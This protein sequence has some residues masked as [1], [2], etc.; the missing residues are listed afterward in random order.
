MRLYAL[1]ALVMGG[2]VIAAVAAVPNLAD[3]MRRILIGAVA[4][5]VIVP[6]ALFLLAGPV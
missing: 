5:L 4:L 3:H 1:Y 6:G 2:I